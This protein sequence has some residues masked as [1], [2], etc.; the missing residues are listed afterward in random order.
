MAIT[1]TTPP[2]RLV[3][4]INWSMLGGLLL[5]FI[6]E[7]V[8]AGSDTPRY[9]AAGLGLAYIVAATILRARAALLAPSG[10]KCAERAL[11]AASL[12]VIAALFLYFR[13]GVGAVTGH[14]ADALA[15]L[16]PILLVCS[17]LPILLAQ[18]AGGRARGGG[19]VEGLRVLEASSGGLTIGLALSLAFVV[20]WLAKARDEKLDLSY[21]R[22]SRPGTATVNMVSSLA[23][24]LDVLLFFPQVNEVKDEV[25]SYFGELAKRSSRA[26]LEAHDRMLS[27]KLAEELKVR[28][29]GVVVLRRGTQTELI[30]L[31]TDLAKARNSLRTL[32]EQV[33]KAVAKV[34]RSPRI[35]YLTVGHGELNDPPADATGERDLKARANLVKSL[36]EL[37]NYKVKDLG[38]TS[39]LGQAVPDDAQV[40]LA[41]GPARA[42]LAEELAALDAYLAKGGALLLAL[43]PE[44]KFELGPLEAR[45]GVKFDRTQLVDDKVYLVDRRNPSDRRGI[46]TDKFSAHASATTLARVRPGEGMALLGAGSLSDLPAVTGQKPPKRTYT[47]RSLSSTFADADG[48]MAFGV[49][50]KRTAYNLVVA[51]ELAAAGDGKDAK[52]PK[53]AK[54]GRALVLADAQLF[55]D[56][57]LSQFE[58][59][60][61]LVADG[62]KWLGGEEAWAGDTKSEKDVEIQHT[63][64]QDVAWFYTTILGA[65]ALVLGGGLLAV[66]RRR[67][68]RP[69]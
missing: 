4:W 6:G 58:L 2:S 68:R 34:A 36:L 21:F 24:P 51:V 69:A 32:D 45:V 15:V 48:D 47:V 37:L 18:L 8:L 49:G 13:P 17:V 23:E 66:H 7:R 63:R 19:R 61:V 64:K 11:L 39:G 27:P 54:G 42:F 26:K 29:D 22:T 55:S 52:D 9:A 25:T 56:Y 1:M 57:V 33:Q 10:A 40:V 46:A 28:K 14:T 53:T 20:A 31:D 50:E 30:T 65:P 67:K 44:S 35:A 5:L 41:L 43:D 3:G 59:N 60:K 38:V 12:G 62:V 16:W